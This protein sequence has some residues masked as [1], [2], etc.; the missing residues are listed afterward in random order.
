[1]YGYSMSLF[2]LRSRKTYLQCLQLMLVFDVKKIY[3]DDI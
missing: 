1:M 2:E 3:D